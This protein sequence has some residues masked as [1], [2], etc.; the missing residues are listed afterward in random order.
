M[1]L[2]QAPIE[3]LLGNH[4]SGPL[5]KMLLPNPEIQPAPDANGVHQD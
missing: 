5:W 1:A 4:R 3:M 2:N